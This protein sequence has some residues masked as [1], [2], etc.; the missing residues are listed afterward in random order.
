LGL[1][2]LVGVINPQ[3]CT[4][5]E[6]YMKHERNTDAFEEW[7]QQSDKEDLPRYKGKMR[8]TRNLIK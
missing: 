6:Q 2:A 7:F 3:Y 1:Q 4:S 8:G 5:D